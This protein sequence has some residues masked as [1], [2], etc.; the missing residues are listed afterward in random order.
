MRAARAE[1]VDGDGGGAGRA[2][3]ADRRPPSTRR[4]RETPSRVFPSRRKPAV[5]GATVA[6]ASRRARH[7]P[8]ASWRCYR[9]TCCLSCDGYRAVIRGMRSETTRRSSSLFF[10]PAVRARL[11]IHAWFVLLY[12]Q[13]SES[14]LLYLV[15]GLLAPIPAARLLACQQRCSAGVVRTR[16]PSVTWE[17]QPAALARALPGGAPS[18]RARWMTFTRMP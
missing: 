6:A 16:T 12:G 8:C 7:A 14:G 10:Q 5:D 4:A 15:V 2:R 13:Q 17:C 3:G 11:R 9:W 1:A 18:R